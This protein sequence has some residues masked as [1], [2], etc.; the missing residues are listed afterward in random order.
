MDIQSTSAAAATQAA[1]SSSPLAQDD[2]DISADF[3]TFL[4]LLTSQLR[5]QD[6]LKPVDSTE[7]I[8][9]LASFSSVEQQTRTNTLLEAM[10]TGNAPSD[11][12]EQAASWIGREVLAPGPAEFDGSEPIEFSVQPADGASKAEL[13]VENDFGLVVTKKTV[14][15]ADVTVAW[16]GRD[17]TGALQPAG[18]YSA[19]VLYFDDSGQ[20]ADRP[21]L[22]FSRVNEARLDG[23]TQKLVLESGTTI[24]PDDVTAVRQSDP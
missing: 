13:I 16:D 10:V 8:A 2:T 6:P 15:P 14:D 20:I 7:F 1:R 22:S 3:E 12:L 23:G 24:T 4:T 17:A 5:N 11:G 21:G 19:R 9:Q 18:D